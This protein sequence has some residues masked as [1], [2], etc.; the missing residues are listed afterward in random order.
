M[1]HITIGMKAENG[2]FRILIS[3]FLSKKHLWHLRDFRITPSYGEDRKYEQPVA[4]RALDLLTTIFNSYPRFFKALNAVLILCKI[5]LAV[6]FAAA[7]FEN[8]LNEIFWVLDQV[9][10]LPVQLFL[11]VNAKYGWR[12][13]ETRFMFANRSTVTA[14]VGVNE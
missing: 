1:H 5:W 12:G 11:A 6:T 14:D 13:I 9:T 8:M 3:R 10:E 2:S 7:R 4:V